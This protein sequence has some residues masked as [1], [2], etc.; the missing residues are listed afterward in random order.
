MKPIIRA[1]VQQLLYIII[2]ISVDVTSTNQLVQ[3][4]VVWPVSVSYYMELISA[5]ESPK[6]NRTK[7]CQIMMHTIQFFE[8]SSLQ[9]G[10]LFPQ[11]DRV[12]I[13]QVE[14]DS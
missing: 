1:A 2:E 10:V 4:R 5:H 6:I 11:T 14:A 8:H 3:Y 7:S 9:D 12:W 13:F